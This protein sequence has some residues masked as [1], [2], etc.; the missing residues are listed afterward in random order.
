M[1]QVKFMERTIDLEDGLDPLLPSTHPHIGSLRPS[2]SCLS[3]TWIADQSAAGAIN[4]CRHHL[5]NDAEGLLQGRFRIIK[6]VMEL[7]QT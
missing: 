6:S 5:G 2:N 1:T 4:R 7:S 3:L